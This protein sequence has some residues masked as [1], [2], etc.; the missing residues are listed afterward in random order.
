MTDTLKVDVN[1]FVEFKCLQERLLV[2]NKENFHLP[3]VVTDLY[4]PYKTLVS[5]YTSMCMCLCMYIYIR[6]FM[7]VFMHVYMCL[8]YA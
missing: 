1:R 2:L 8:S 4:L 6:V 5:K 7:F 3:V